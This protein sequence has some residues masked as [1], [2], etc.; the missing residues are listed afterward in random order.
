MAEWA[1][2]IEKRLSGLETLEQAKN[3]E[4]LDLHQSFPVEEDTSKFKF[5]MVAHANEVLGGKIKIETPEGL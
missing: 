1:K 2:G 4:A 5:D 3:P